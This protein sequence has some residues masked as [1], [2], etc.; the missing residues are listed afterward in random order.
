MHICHTFQ[1]ARQ[2]KE[3]RFI[4]TYQLTFGLINNIRNLYTCWGE[5]HS[6]ME[7]S[8]DAVVSAQ[9][10]AAKQNCNTLL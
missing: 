8:V 1:M 9:V 3:I 10:I 4:Y 7:N 2:H 5:P 6:Y